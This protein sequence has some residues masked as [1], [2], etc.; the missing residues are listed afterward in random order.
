MIDDGL[1]D[2]GRWV[3]RL[4][5]DPSQILKLHKVQLPGDLWSA[6]DLISLY[7]FDGR[8]KVTSGGLGREMK[9]AGFKQALQGAQVRTAKGLQRLF[10]VRNT[11][12]WL[13]AKHAELTKHYDNTRRV[14]DL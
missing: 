9:R 12:K 2:L 5:T 7:E 6:Q 4:L 11:D 8:I 10:I 1:S 14:L 13:N 3:R